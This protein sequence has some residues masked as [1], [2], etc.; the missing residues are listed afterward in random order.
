MK[1]TPNSI[2]ELRLDQI[3]VDGGTCARDGQD[4]DVI[5]AYAVDMM[6]AATFPPLVAFFDGKT[7][8]LADG[9]YRHAAARR[10]KKK[11]FLVDVREG[12]RRDA[13]LY[14]CS[15]N[16]R[17]GQPKTPADKRR[18][19]EILLT[20]P[21]W[22][23]WN[24]LEIARRCGVSEITV[25]RIRL[26]MSP[27]S[28]VSKMETRTV[29]RGGRTYEMRTEHI[30]RSAGSA[31]KAT[32]PPEAPAEPDVDAAPAQLD[33]YL[34]NVHLTRKARRAMQDLRPLFST[35]DALINAALLALARESLVSWGA[36]S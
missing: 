32:S 21:E 14:A 35:K 34:F 27:S 25:R 4:P 7:Y 22:S 30:G 16:L 10:A 12:T 23:R 31:W 36:D 24:N 8:W 6:D 3:R 9:F 15:A 26:E 20:D 18:C 33:T 29:Q 13:L 28:T 11:C 1:T 5:Q 2:Q 19:V 17:H